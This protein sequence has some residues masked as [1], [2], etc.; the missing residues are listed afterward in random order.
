[1]T[2]CQ[3]GRPTLQ[4]KRCESG[5]VTKRFTGHHKLQ[6]SESG[7]LMEHWS[8]LL[9]AERRCYLK[10]VLYED[11][12]LIS[13]KHYMHWIKDLHVALY[14]QERKDSGMTRLTITPITPSDQLAAFCFLPHNCGLCRIRGLIL[15]RKHT[16]PR[17]TA[18][19]TLNYKLSLLPIAHW[20]PGVKG[21]VGKKSGHL[22]LTGVSDPDHSEEVGCCYT[23]CM[24]QYC[25]KAILLYNIKILYNLAPLV[26]VKG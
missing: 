10:A 1:M 15:H 7:R 23:I 21:P 8:S 17:G 5:P 25:I 14:P 18:R 19:L 22:I 26:T 20:A 24:K 16:F 6:H 2:S 3:T 9:K 12:V 4:Q 13:R 11:W